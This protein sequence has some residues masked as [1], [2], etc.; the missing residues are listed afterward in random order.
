MKYSGLLDHTGCPLPM[1]RA[2]YYESASRGRRLHGMSQS[3]VGPNSALSSDWTKIV[4]ASRAANR[5]DPWIRNGIGSLVSNE[6]G[7]GIRPLA[8][9]EDPELNEFLDA[10][11]NRWVDQSDAD[12][13]LNFYGQQTQGCKCRRTAGEVFVRF[14]PRRLGDGLVVPLQIQMLEPEMCPINYNAIAPNG[15]TVHQGIEKTAFG[16]RTAYWMYRQHPGDATT[17][18]IRDARLPI[19]VSANDVIHH[20]FPDRPGML[21]GEPDPAASLVRAYI[22]GEYEGAEL[23]RKKDRAHFTGTIEREEFTDADFTHDPFTGNPLETDSSGAPMADVEPGTFPVMKPGEK[24]NLFDGEDS[25]SPDFMRHELMAI[26]AGMDGLPVE[27]LSGDYSKINDRLLRGILNEFHRRIEARQDQLTI[28]QI[29]RQV[30][31]RWLDVAVLSGA[32]PKISIADYTSNTEYFRRCEWRA[33]AW[34]Y[35]NKLQDVQ[36]DREAIDGGLTSRSAVIAERGGWDRKSVDKQ[37]AADKESEESLK[38][39][40]EPRKASAQQ[41]QPVDE[42]TAKM[43]AVIEQVLSGVLTPSDIQ[44]EIG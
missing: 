33:P 43:R 21:R 12:G 40:S 22:Y 31:N 2:S 44:L 20:Y 39:K 38:L 28:H 16:L 35:L 3:S 42:K 25:F 30:R 37:R 5:N 14:R 6:I 27:I 41:G 10:L 11:W 13:V 23:N 19:R 9:T 4:Q 29:C 34:P 15:N 36:A 24:V 18:F 26:A 32:V 8:M 7:I 1:A 17:G